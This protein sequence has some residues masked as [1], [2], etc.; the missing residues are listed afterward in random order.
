V[1]E[2]ASKRRAELAFTFLQ[3]LEMMTIPIRC[4]ALLSVLLGAF[5]VACGDDG[6]G[7]PGG[8]GGS[9]GSGGG[10]SQTSAE[11]SGEFARVMDPYTPNTSI[12]D[13]GGFV[14]DEEGLVFSVIQ[15]AMSAAEADIEMYPQLILKSDLAGNMETLYTSDEIIGQ[16]FVQGDD[17]YFVDGLLSRAI[18]RIPR[19]GGEAVPL[20]DTR[21]WAGPVQSGGLFYYAARPN[22]DSAAPAG[23]AAIY[24]LDPSTGTS[25]LLVDQGETSISAIA[26]DGGTI[27]WVETGDILSDTEPYTIWSMPA[28]GGAAQV[29]MT[30]PNGTAIGN[31]RVVDGVAYGNTLASFTSVEIHRIP[32]GGTPEVVEDNGGFPMLIA[33]DA[34]YYGANSGLIKNT[35]SFDDPSVIEGTSGESIYSLAMGPT[36][37]WYSLGPCI[38]RLPQ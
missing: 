25:T 20:T 38:Y 9:G 21:L 34:I 30:I 12:E 24:S 8:Q 29:V 35:L 28:A 33:G 1:S 2:G 11:C 3:R 27:Y 5:T 15:N 13:W 4:S 19:A 17:V 6:G 26:L 37:L 22:F 16:I 7:S 36:D 31:F 14:A 32:L 10:T 23:D 18:Y